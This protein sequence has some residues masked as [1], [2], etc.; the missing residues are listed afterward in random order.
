MAALGRAVDGIRDA[1]GAPRWADPASLHVTLAFLG[2][3]PRARLTGLLSALGPAVVGS[4]AVTLQLTGAGRFGGRRPRVLW[5]GVG[6]DVDALTV[7]ADRLAAAAR[8]AGVPVDERP[9]RPHLTLGRWPGPGTPDVGLVDRLAGDHGPA[10]P[11]TEVVLWRS[12]AGRPHERVTG[13]PSAH[14]A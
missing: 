5:A 7:L 4:R 1:P 9:F 14:Q 10:W 3:V 2:D 6:G 11:V 13:W 8:H 12:P